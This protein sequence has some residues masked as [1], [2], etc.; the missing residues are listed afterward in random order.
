MLEVVSLP[1]W[2]LFGLADDVRSAL[3]DMV[4]LDR[5]AVLATLYRVVGGSPRPAGSQMLIS[6]ERLSGF[7]SGGCIEGDIAVHAAHVATTGRPQHLI[8]GDGGPFPDIRLVCGGRVEILLE[9]IAPD[10]PAVHR[11]LD[12]AEARRPAL[13]VSDGEARAC[14]SADHAPPLLSPLLAKAAHGLAD[15]PAARCVNVDGSA[16]GL[17][18]DPIKRMI[19]VG[20]DPTAIAIASLAQ[21]SGFETWLVRSKGPETPPPLTGVGYDRRT[22]DIALPAIGLDP[23]TYVAVATHDFESDEAALTTALP[24]SAAYVGV[25][26]ARRRL[27]ERLARLTSLGVA[28][29]ALD[30]LKAPIGLNLGGKAPFEIAIAVLAEIIAHR[31]EI[32][33]QPTETAVSLRRA[34]A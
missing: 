28:S 15:A 13:W 33:S 29:I 25:L 5:P 21:Q 8:Y 22:P 11:L 14:W 34:G 9:R 12:L 18:F 19:V 10:D 1:D 16:L 30:R 2:P 20:G 27:P 6:P 7:M 31:P 17:R 4:Q 32:R 23:W 26:G 3:G 24:S